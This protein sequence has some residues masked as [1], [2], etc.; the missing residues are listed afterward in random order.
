MGWTGR[1]LAPNGFRWG[2]RSTRS[3]PMSQ[4]THAVITRTIGID[5][6]KHTLHSIALDDRV[7]IPLREKLGRSRISTRLP[8]IPPCLI[9]IEAGMATHYVAR[10]LI[11]L[12]PAGGQGT[13]G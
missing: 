13:A 12:G 4:K 5:T 6:R 3:I 9:G 7:T 10:D 1:A 2:L 8:N 11:L